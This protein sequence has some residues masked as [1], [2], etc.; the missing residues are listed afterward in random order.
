MDL[1]LPN[2]IGGPAMAQLSAVGLS[3]AS[4]IAYDPP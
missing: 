1:N 3:I 2:P 4:L